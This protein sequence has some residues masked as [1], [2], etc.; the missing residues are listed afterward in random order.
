MNERATFFKNNKNLNDYIKIMNDNSF[1]LDNYNI[2]FDYVADIIENWEKIEWNIVYEI[3]ELFNDYHNENNWIGDIFNERMITKFQAILFK[4]NRVYNKFLDI[5][6]DKSF[7]ISGYWIKPSQINNKIN[8]GAK[9]QYKIALIMLDIFNTYFKSDY[10]IED[11][12]D[13]QMLMNYKPAYNEVEYSYEDDSFSITDWIDKIFD[14]IRIAF[15][16]LLW[17]FKIKKEKDINWSKN[18]DKNLLMIIIILL[19]VLFLYI[20]IQ[21]IIPYFL[22]K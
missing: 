12:F 6:E 2:D 15:E 18:Y 20:N 17:F 3:I 7:K 21:F 9:M 10:K 13:I 16:N 14:S 11:I 4:N 19:I 5:L 1:S 8:T 22:N